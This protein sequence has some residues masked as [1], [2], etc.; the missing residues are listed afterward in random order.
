MRDALGQEAEANWLRFEK[1]IV[2]EAR[3][4]YPGAQVQH[5]AHVRGRISG[6]LRQIDVLVT[7]RVGP[8]EIMVVI[9]C[10]WRRRPADVGV[11]D[12]LVGKLQDVG[13]DRGVLFANRLPTEAALNR[14]RNAVQPRLDGYVFELEPRLSWN[15][16]HAI[17]S[18]HEWFAFDEEPL[19][20]KAEALLK[21]AM[22]R[23]RLG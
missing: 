16:A 22:E 10:K 17:V 12:S 21:E 5:N 6:K 19:D 20:P 1:R 23:L 15:E 8:H 7:A 4:M 3:R 2:E 14:M 18:E 11:V 9:E 13:A